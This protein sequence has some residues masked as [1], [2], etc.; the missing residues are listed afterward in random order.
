MENGVLAAQLFTVRW[1]LAAGRALAVLRFHGGK[2]IAPQIQRMRAEDLLAAVF[3]QALACQENILGDI[4]IPDHPLVRETMK[5]LLT[6]ALHIDGLKRVLPDLA[7]GRSIGPA[8]ATPAPP[9]S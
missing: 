7:P 5:G 6:E 8:A 9:S 2:K 4:C 1:R 3:P